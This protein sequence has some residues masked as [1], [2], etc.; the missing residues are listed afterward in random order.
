MV[1]ILSANI[2]ETLSYLEACS[3]EDIYYISEVFEDISERLQSR[4]YIMCL[5]KL[6]KKY[7]ELY[8]TSDI[9][10]AEGYVE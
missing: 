3:A 10:L 1:D 7:P 2:E 9:D 8:L 6:D 5:R 4:E